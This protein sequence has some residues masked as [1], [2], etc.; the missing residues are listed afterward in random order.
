MESGYIE[1][2]LPIIGIAVAASWV[3]AIYQFVSYFGGI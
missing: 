2:L 1:A 3:Y